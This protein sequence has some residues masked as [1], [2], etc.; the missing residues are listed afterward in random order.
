MVA[1]DLV[2]SGRDRWEPT[3][4]WGR[5]P[6]PPAR[7]RE[8]A[9]YG[10][11]WHHLGVSKTAPQKGEALR[12]P[13]VMLR[14][15]EQ[16]TEAWLTNRYV[17]AG[18]TVEQVAADAGVCTQTIYRALRRHEIPLRSK[19]MAGKPYSLGDVLTEE[20]LRDTY[21][22]EGRSVR[23]I[24]EEVGYSEAAVMARLRRYDIPRRG[25]QPAHM[26]VLAD[27][28]TPSRLAEELEIDHNVA[29]IARKLRADT[30]TVRAYINRYG[31]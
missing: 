2:D 20:F 13:P 12:R 30:G 23:S 15:Q 10:K 8:R 22:L 19:S 6:Q 26:R 27:T 31:L 29:R 9:A 1:V 14:Y 4:P 7:A 28:L 21:E 17:D 16:L 24:A 3:Q 11:A 5:R 18:R 25:A